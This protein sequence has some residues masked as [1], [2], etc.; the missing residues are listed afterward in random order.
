MK[1]PRASEGS[2]SSNNIFRGKSQWYEE[3][4]ND[5]FSLEHAWIVKLL[6]YALN[7]I[8]L[9]KNIFYLCIYN[10]IALQDKIAS[11]WIFYGDVI[12]IKSYLYFKYFCNNKNKQK[13]Q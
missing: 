7:L 8:V 9:L 3:S 5:L 10:K 1:N 11:L 4:S 2:M 12:L 6:I 13:K